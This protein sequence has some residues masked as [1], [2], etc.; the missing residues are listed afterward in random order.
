MIST[1]KK[2]RDKHIAS[3]VDYCMTSWKEVRL[4]ERRVTARM[5]VCVYVC[6]R[7]TPFISTFHFRGPEE[8]ENNNNLFFKIKLLV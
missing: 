8:Q 6:I 4:L 5:Y 2:W 1:F 3:Q 7:D